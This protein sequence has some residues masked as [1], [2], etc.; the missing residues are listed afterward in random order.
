MNEKQKIREQQKKKQEERDENAAKE[1]GRDR[2]R[3]D[4]NGLN[5]NKSFEM[6]TKPVRSGGEFVWERSEGEVRVL[7]E[8][9]EIQSE[10]Q[11]ER[12]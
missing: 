4:E 5:E 8:N 12:N 2:K 7:K 6:K 1:R 11:R 9:T 3:E 10:R